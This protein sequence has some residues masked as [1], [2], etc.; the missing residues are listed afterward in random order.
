MFRG[1]DA[2]DARRVLQ[3]CGLTDWERYVLASD[4][5]I[6]VGDILVSPRFPN[7]YAQY[8]GLDGPFL[9]MHGEGFKPGQNYPRYC[10]KDEQRRFSRG[11]HLRM[12]W[13]ESPLANKEEQ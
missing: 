7:C 5:Q 2:N 10:D 11:V 9:Q 12:R 3:E 1:F 13:R 6:W 4:D 8:H